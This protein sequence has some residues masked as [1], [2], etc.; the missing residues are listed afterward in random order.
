TY[1]FYLDSAVD[2]L[3][4]NVVLGLFTWSDR[5]DYNHREIDQEFARWG[6]PN[7]QNAQYVVQPYTVPQNIH[8]FDW[9]S[10]ILSSLHSF[11]WQNG[12]VTFQS[13]RGQSLPPSPAD[14]VQEWT[15]QSSDVPV[16]GDENAR[17]NLWL[18]RGRPP[19]NGQ[20]VEV[21][22]NKFEFVP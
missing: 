15:L 9:P 21:I 19:S 11:Q 10:G 18:F 5:D 20:A 2:N 22:I 16:P 14:V 3:D 12:S 6:D 8:R 7:N 17:I 1:R 4:R 13:I